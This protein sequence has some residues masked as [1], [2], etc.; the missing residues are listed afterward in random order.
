M[1]KVKKRLFGLEYDHFSYHLKIETSPKLE[2]KL[3]HPLT[4]STLF[5][6]QMV[7]KNKY[8]KPKVNLDLKSE[9]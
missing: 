3:K 1:R 8:L 6:E 4:D 5:K 7:I 2:I 9:S